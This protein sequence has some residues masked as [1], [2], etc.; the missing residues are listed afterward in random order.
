MYEKTS[1]P[2]TPEIQTMIK[3]YIAV[4]GKTYKLIGKDLNIHPI[5]LFQLVNSNKIK[6]LTKTTYEKLSLILE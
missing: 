2:L 4:S 3:N 5:H 1:I 6:R